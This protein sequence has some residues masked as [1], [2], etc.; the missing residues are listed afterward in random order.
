MRGDFFWIN[1][2]SFPEFFAQ[3]PAIRLHDPLADFLG[4]AEDGVLDYGYTDAV[5]LTG[6]SCPTVASAYN[7]TR[8]AL[9]ALY[10][11]GVAER[12]AL[13]VQF[14]D[15]RDAGATGVMAAVVGLITG[16]AD[17]GGFKGLGHNFGRRNLLTFAAPVPLL[18][19]ISRL[20]TG[21]W[22]DAD[23]DLSSVPADP[24][25]AELLPASLA[26]YAT[27]E[28]RRQFGRFWQARV[29]AILLEHGE[30]PAVFTLRLGHGRRL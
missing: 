29:A 4:A 15:A 18:L 26:G 27:P 8:L 3:V 1:A 19:R 13:A 6:H 30:D 14:R 20:D 16:A 7:L 25:M 9:C 5:R 22:V 17:D 12:G 24:A 10:P 21:D 11:E 2:M 23:C 28:Q